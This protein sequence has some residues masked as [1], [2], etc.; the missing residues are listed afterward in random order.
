LFLRPRSIAD[1]RAAGA[2]AFAKTVPRLAALGSYPAT[3][4]NLGFA[5]PGIDRALLFPPAI[6]KKRDEYGRRKMMK[7]NNRF[8]NG[9]S[10]EVNEDS[11]DANMG[12]SA[13][14]SGDIDVDEDSV[15]VFDLYNVCNGALYE[16]TLDVRKLDDLSP[17]EKAFL[18]V[19]RLKEVWIHVASG[20]AECEAIIDTLNWARG[21]LR[22][23]A[24]DSHPS[25]SS[26]G[27]K[28]GRVIFS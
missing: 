8:H 19:E 25:G 7:G 17:E 14:N 27:G 23:N 5:R 22:D 13:A 26:S 20:C 3:I 6:Q 10:G 16:G 15:D 2:Q 28:S 12:I 9:D 21:M 1:R 24:K 11:V 18:N 4:R